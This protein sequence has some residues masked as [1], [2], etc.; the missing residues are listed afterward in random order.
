MQQ[1]LIAIKT[2]SPVQFATPAIDWD[3]GHSA[4]ARLRAGGAVHQRSKR[5]GLGD[6]HLANQQVKPHPST[7]AHP[8]A[9]AVPRHA[10]C[11]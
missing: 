6:Q 2:T 10:R 1:A 5:A 11:L 3:L 9:A 4:P 8:P 7:F